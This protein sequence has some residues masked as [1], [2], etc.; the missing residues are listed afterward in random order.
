MTGVTWLRSHI[1][2]HSMTKTQTSG[3]LS[4][5]K[6]FVFSHLLSPFAI[7]IILEGKFP[8]F[9][10]EYSLVELFHIFFGNKV[11]RVFFYQTIWADKLFILTN[12]KLNNSTFKIGIGVVFSRERT[13]DAFFRDFWLPLSPSP[14]RPCVS[15]P[16]NTGSHVFAG[17]LA[18]ETTFCP[19][20]RHLFHL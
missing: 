5:R 11:F 19:A 3:R 14:L 7:A 16:F 6:N 9:F 2:C 12:L 1:R 8:F 18:T 15:Y 13:Y 17:Q 20:F 4:A 10:V